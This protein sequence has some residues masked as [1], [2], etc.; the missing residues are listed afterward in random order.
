MSVVRRFAAAALAALLTPAACASPPTRTFMLDAPPPA[1]PPVAVSP[2]AAPLHVDAVHL[3]PW[4]DRPELVRR[5]GAREVKVD[6]FARWSAPVAQ[7]ARRTL[8]EDLMARLPRGAVVFPDSPVP[9]GAVG[10]VV[11]VLDVVREGDRA[12]MDVSWTRLPA[13]AA[14]GSPSPSPAGHPLRLTAPA[15]ARGQGAA[16]ADLAALLAALADAIA[17][18]AAAA[19]R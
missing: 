10:L 14:P 1:A 15:S 9:Q 12:V 2:L 7:L 17:A 16:A 11:D 13:P 19:S 6:D 3:P 4:M 8:T 5:V 18:D